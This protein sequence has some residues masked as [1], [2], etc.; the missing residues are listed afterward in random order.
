MTSNGK[1]GL[2][3]KY[4]KEWQKAHKAEV[5]AWI[6]DNP[7]TPEPKPEDLA[8]PFFVSSRSSTP[9][10]SPARSIIR[11]PTARPKRSWSR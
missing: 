3:G 11:S 7:S 5:D 2:C 8:V 9:A 10:R 1:Y 4:V 6:K